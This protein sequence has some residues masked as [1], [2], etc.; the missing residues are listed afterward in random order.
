M[1]KKYDVI[2]AGGGHAGVEAALAAA[3]YGVKTLLI[4]INSNDIATMPCNP[5]IGGIAK[6][7]LVFELDALG[8]EM[9]YNTDCTGI[10]FRVLNTKKGPAVR[11]NRVQCDKSAYS[12]R[13]AAIVK[14][15]ASLDI[16]ESTAKGIS[17]ENG[18]LKG[19]ILEDGSLIESKTV[20]ITAGTYLSGRIHIG[21]H[22][23]PGGRGDVHSA[24]ELSQSIRELGFS[25][26][27]LKTGTPPRLDKNSLDYSKMSIQP[28]MEP[29]PLFSWQAERD[30]SNNQ[31]FHVEH[32]AENG[33]DVPRGTNADI[34][35]PWVPGSDQLPCYLTHTTAE[36]HEIIADNLS[37][38]SL[39]GGAIEGT[40]VRYCPSIEDKIVKFSGAASHHVFIEPEGRSTNLIYP[41]GTSNSLPEDIQEQMIHSIPGL[42]RAIILEWAY[43]IEYDFIDPT[44]LTHS[45][46]SKLVEGLFFAGQ[47]NGTT[48]YEE[49]AVQG[50]VAGVNAARKTCA[51]SP[52]TLKRSEAYIGVLIDDLVTKGTDEP[53]RMFTSRAEH[54]LTLRQDNARFRLVGHAEQ[55]KIANS[56][57]IAE[58][59]E[60]AGLIKNEI[61]R[62]NSVY[63]S[64]VSEAQL[65]RRPENGYIDLKSA[66]NDLPASV[67]K[68][69][70]IDIKYAGYIEREKKRIEKVRLL[71]QQEIPVDTDYWKID[72]ISYESR[73]KLS[74]IRP[75][76]I[77]QAARIPGISP[78]DIAILAI[79]AKS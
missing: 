21:Q 56:E 57:Y 2:V 61:K 75:E 67:I 35:S 47:V 9:A 39:Y 11:A 53:Y 33:D 36:T 30:I 68:Q 66:N 26:A 29:P 64:E 50:F 28:G 46:E 3:R 32:L 59:K 69:V 41:N 65:L 71:E 60:F 16:I 13:M 38:S 48:G 62:L 25:M 18:R 55:L 49:A 23:R 63:L 19:V 79:A 15:T 77:A 6:S 44:Q 27:R 70:E 76:N 1:N 14:Q 17:T 5:A 58:T 4:T 52:W 31:M 42:E 40:G 20:I 8:G 74:R 34:V 72:T 43:A 73:E 10:Q 54:R 51:E 45:L 12:S 37:K 24:D 7:H 78:A 22:V